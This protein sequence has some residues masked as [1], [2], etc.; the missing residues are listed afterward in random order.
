[1]NTAAFMVQSFSRDWAS[2]IDRRHERLFVEQNY[3]ATK[4]TVRSFAR[5]WMKDLNDRGIRVNALS[6]GSLDTPGLNDL[7]ASSDTEQKRKR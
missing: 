7:L 3:S 5:T 4:A 2:H 6:P 1:M